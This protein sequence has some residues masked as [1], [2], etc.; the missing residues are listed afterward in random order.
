MHSFSNETK[1]FVFYCNV[2]GL[3]VTT[4]KVNRNNNKVLKVE[5]HDFLWAIMR[6]TRELYRATRKLP[7]NY[8][9]FPKRYIERAQE[10][11][12]FKTEKAPQFQDRVIKREVFTYGMHRP[13]EKEFYDENYPGKHI[14]QDIVEP[15]KDWTIYKGDKVEVMKGKDKGK[16]GFVNYVVTERNWVTVEGLNCEYKY[17]GGEFGV[18]KTMM[19]EELPLLVTNE[20]ALLDPSDN[21]PTQVVW[22][23]TD[24]GEEV[25]VSARTGRI[26]PIPEAALETYDYK[27]KRYYVEQPKDTPAAEVEK[28]T[29]KPKLLTFEQEIMQEMGIKEENE[30][31][32]TYWY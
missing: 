15:I 17:V 27:I 7:L 18:P 32:K 1:Q 14:T 24:A 13:W 6:L 26:I 2:S 20:V 4:P 10:Q 8:S 5:L 28:I 11:I 3:T 31:C 12:E 22:R 9:N 29:F 19:A 21:K 30:P 23:F 25:R 16:Q